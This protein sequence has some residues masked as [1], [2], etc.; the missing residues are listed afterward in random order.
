M[1]GRDHGRCLTEETLTEYLE[2]GLDPPVKAASEVHLIA[3]DNCRSRLGFYMRLLAQEV[4]AEELGGDGCVELLLRERRKVAHT[5]ERAG[6]VFDLHHQHRVYA[7]IDRAQ[8]LQQGR[9]R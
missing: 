6:L 1:R 8:V 5:A 9:E 7:A 2:G 3:C 4:S